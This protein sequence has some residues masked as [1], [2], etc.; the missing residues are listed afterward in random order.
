MGHFIKTSGMTQML[1]AWVPLR[2]PLIYITGVFEVLAAIAV[3]IPPLSRP[4]GLVLCVY[5]ILIFPSNV[6]AAFQRVDFG[7]HEMGPAYLLV[8]LPL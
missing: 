2:V 7:G 6:Y 4:V 1:P 8:R 5:L 3:L